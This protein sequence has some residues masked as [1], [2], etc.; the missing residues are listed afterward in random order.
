MSAAS[1]SDDSSTAARSFSFA[2][3]VVPGY[4]PPGGR[5]QRHLAWRAGKPARG[6]FRDYGPAPV[7][8]CFGVRAPLRAHGD[9]KIRVPLSARG[10]EEAPQLARHI[11]HVRIDVCVHTRFPRT[12]ETAQIGLGARADRVPLVCE[13]LLDDIDAGDLEGQPMRELGA[14]IEAHGP[15]DPYPGGKSLHDAAR[16]GS[17]RAYAAWQPVPNGSCSPYATNCRSA[18]RSTPRRVPR[19]STNPSI[20]S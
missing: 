5:S 8:T 10:R 12:L 3:I 2:V 9:P 18:S 4:R 16:A 1:A 19:T 13:A 14:W 6:D 20:R 15:D 17:P 7:K 11:A